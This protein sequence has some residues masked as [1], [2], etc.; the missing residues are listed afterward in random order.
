MSDYKDRVCKAREKLAD[1]IKSFESASET[2]ANQ[3]VR[4]DECDVIERIEVD[5][6]STSNDYYDV[7]VEMPQIKYVI[8][9]LDEYRDIMHEV[10]TE[11]D[12][13]KRELNEQSEAPSTESPGESGSVF[14][15]E[16]YD[17]LL[18]ACAEND[19]SRIAEHVHDG[20]ELLRSA[21]IPCRIPQPQV[22]IADTETIN[23][24]IKDQQEILKDNQT[25]IDHL[26]YIQSK[27]DSVTGLLKTVAGRFGIESIDDM[28]S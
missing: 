22:T 21:E 5:A 3:E 1:E 6:L 18:Q 2:L 25:I 4:I 8:D 27:L 11:N 24:L 13:L 12:K 14:F 15:K 19:E 16:Y 10:L 7:E 26:L 9:A 28:I 20:P 17:E 23:S